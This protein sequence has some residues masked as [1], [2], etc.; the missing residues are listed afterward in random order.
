LKQLEEDNAKLKRLVA[1]LS[2]GKIMVQ[3]ALK[4][5][6]KA[7]MAARHHSLLVRA[8]RGEGAA[9]RALGMCSRSLYR[10]RSRRDPRTELRAQ[11]REIAQARVRYGYRRVHVLLD[12]E[13]WKASH[14]L[15]YRL[16]REEGLS[17]RRKR[18]KRHVS[19]MHRERAS[20]RERPPRLGAKTSWPTSSCTA[21]AFVRLRWSISSPRN[22]WRSRWVSP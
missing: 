11:I 2:L 6:G 1:D 20:L 3:D 8:L 9:G 10:Y 22:A 14:K 4:K 7:R 13:G 21:R 19:A 16:Y 17:L 5:S 15:V 18:S 12:R